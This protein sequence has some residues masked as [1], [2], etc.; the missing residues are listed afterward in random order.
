M[1]RVFPRR[2]NWTPAD[3]LAFVGEPPLFRPRDRRIPVRV[4]A[5]F[6]WDTVQ[7]RRLGRSWAK[8]YD[9]V[10]VG[11]P[12]F[13]DPGEEFV[14]GRFVKP[15]VTITSRGCLRRCPW[16]YVPTREGTIRELPIRAGHIV[17]DNNLLACTDRH[18]E[19][20]FDMLRE[21]RK[22]AT[23][24]GGLDT[25]LLTDR[26]RG[27]LGSIKVNEIWTAC[28]STDHSSLALLERAAA[29]LD[30]YPIGK[31]R[32]YVLLAYSEHE[33]L[34]DAERRLE[35]VYELGFLPF[36]QLYQDTFHP[37]WK[38]LARKWSRPA[39]YRNREKETTVSIDGEELD[40]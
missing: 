22:G 20:V 17:Q 37:E 4:S 27:L 26:H 1:I 7:A 6:T 40:T 28:D 8:H 13:G 12:G 2:T 33:T 25:G 38:A 11:G 24:S 30:G 16:C 23:F 34:A 15:G 3:G 31:L 39:L 5:T 18:I 29:I 14:P 10:Q 36:A 32:C 9:D 19:A 35:T 21:Q